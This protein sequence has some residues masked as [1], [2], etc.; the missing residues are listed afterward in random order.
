MGD[1]EVKMD[2]ELRR[3]LES[4]PPRVQAVLTLEHGAVPRSSA[5][6]RRVVEELLRRVER[7]VGSSP[8]A[9]NVFANLGRFAVEASPSFVRKLVEQDEIARAQANVYP[10]EDR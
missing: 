2:A 5:D 3:Q 1:A 6:T 8:A 10:E 7:E 4:D 9:S